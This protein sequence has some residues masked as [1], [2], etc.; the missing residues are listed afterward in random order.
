MKTVETELREA[1]AA[2]TE[3]FM[4]DYVRHLEHHIKQIPGPE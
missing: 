2:F 3:Y 1:V 4:R